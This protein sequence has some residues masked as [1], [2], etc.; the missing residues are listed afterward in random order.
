MNYNFKI[1]KCD[2]FTQIGVVDAVC[3]TTNGVVKYNGELVMG[4]G[5]AKQ[6]ANTFPMLPKLLGDKVSLYGNHVYHVG[7]VGN[8]A[9]LSYPTKHNYSDN[10]DLNLI[11]R[12]AK[13]LVKWVNQSGAKS[14][15]IPSPGTGLGGLDKSLVYNALNDILDERFTI[16]TK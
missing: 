3:V 14:I 6:F 16:V 2:I 1:A 4:A 10:S 12:S 13:R 9:I 5:V 11:I 7:D 15:L 8:T